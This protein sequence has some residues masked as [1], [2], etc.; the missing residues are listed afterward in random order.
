MDG[1]VVVFVQ[2][3]TTVYTVKSEDIVLDCPYFIYSH[4]FING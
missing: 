3:S 4:F 1:K 2:V